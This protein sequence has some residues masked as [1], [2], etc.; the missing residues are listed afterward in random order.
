MVG[1]AYRGRIALED[2]RVDFEVEPIELP[3]GNGFGG[4]GF[5]VREVVTLKGQI[6]ES[7]RIRLER[8]SRYCPVGQAL[9]KGSIQ[10][11]DEVEWSSG[12]VAAAAPNPAGV[13][14]LAG[15]IAIVPTGSVHGRY[16][17]DTKEYDDEGGMA[18]EGEVKVAV[19][20]E[21]LTHASLWT[22]LAGHSSDGWVPGPFPLSQAAWAA[23]SAATLSQLLGQ[24]TE[25]ADSI[26]VEL[27]MAARGGRGR[28]QGDAAAG[29]VG[30]RSAVRRVIVPGSPRTTPL[31][32]VQ[33]ALQRDPI[34]IAYRNGGLLLHDEVVVE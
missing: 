9:T 8:A 25:G 27:A 18:H 31:E 29:V 19:T 14:P 28:A 7:E 16:L 23:S 30:H 11:Q 32:V 33:A 17:L 34:T 24:G 21:N 20:C 13:L 12:D 10:F 5:G 6:S 26:S 3:T 2:I 1:V 15:D 4:I 22:V